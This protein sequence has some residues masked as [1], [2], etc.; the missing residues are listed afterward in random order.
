MDINLLS[1]M[2]A[3]LILD[4]D[5]VTLPGL[6]TFV[7]EEV[8]SSFSDRGYTINPPYRKLSFRQ[9]ESSDTRLV[10]FYSSSNRLDPEFA[11]SILSTFL[12][13]MKVFLLS[14]KTVVFPGLGRLRA[15]KENNFFFIPDESLDVYPDGF[16]LES[17]SLKTHFETEEEQDAAEEV[18]LSISES[19][20]PLTVEISDAVESIEPVD[21]SVVEPVDELVPEPVDEPIE[22]PVDEPAPEPVD[23]TVEDTESGTIAE[24]AGE[25][26]PETVEA[27]V[28]EPDND[29]PDETVAGVQ[30]EKDAVLPEGGKRVVPEYLK[31]VI[32]VVAAAAVLFGV[33][34]LLAHTAPDFTDTLLYSSEDL[35]L[36]RSL[37]L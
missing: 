10:D 7:A 21:D 25:S 27:G 20:Y 13:E 3:E 14:K 18:L 2:V 32:G 4:N 35:E 33:F 22:E 26:V 9:R 8:P 15:T 12:S 1:K 5:E 29:V 24:N 6:G 36:I 11:S 31:I 30:P 17:V 16:G 37:K 28:E 23:E 19:E 34:I